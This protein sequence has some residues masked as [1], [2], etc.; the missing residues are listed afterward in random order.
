MAVS[1]IPSV[2]SYECES[3]LF[4]TRRVAYPSVS[5]PAADSCHITNSIEPQRR[6]R[7]ITAMTFPTIENRAEKCL[8]LK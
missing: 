4:N 3:D 1:W 7:Q 8:D 5:N 2:Y 6:D